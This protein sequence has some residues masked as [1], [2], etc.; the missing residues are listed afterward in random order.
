VSIVGGRHDERLD[1]AHE[2]WDERWADDAGRAPWL[3]PE[4]RVLALMPALHASGPIAVLD[5]GAGVGR[6]ALAHARAGDTVVAVDASPTGV[7][8]IVE[9]ARGHRLDVDARVGAFTAVP[10][11]DAAVDHVLAWNVLYHG[12]T[13][14]AEQGLRECARVLRPGGT[15]QFTMLST[16]HRAFGAGREVRPNTWVDDRSASDKG[17]P[18]LYVDGVTLEA[19]LRRTGFELRSM[20]DVDQLPTGSFHWTVLTERP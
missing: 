7:A 15:M 3:D 12:D 13:E 5:L 19:M 17:H 18:H 2:L 9:A 11:A 4:P 16:R 10:V 14:I 1:T 8:A 6:H 20:V